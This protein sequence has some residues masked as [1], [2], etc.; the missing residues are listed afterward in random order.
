M[1]ALASESSRSVGKMSPGS[2]SNPC[3]SP[4]PSS[5]SNTSS[6]VAEKAPAMVCR[7]PFR[8][9][10]MMIFMPLGYSKLSVMAEGAKE[11]VS[12]DVTATV[13]LTAPWNR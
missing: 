7:E 5:V 6:E 4:P 10:L 12:L 2:S 13:G 11:T 1:T 9:P 8:L 3:G